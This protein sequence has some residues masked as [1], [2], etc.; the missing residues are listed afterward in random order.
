LAQKE[1]N[2]IDKDV[3]L[4]DQMPNAIFKS[5]TLEWSTTAGM[6]REKKLPEHYCY[7]N[8]DLLVEVAAEIDLLYHRVFLEKL[9]SNAVTCDPFDCGAPGFTNKPGI[10]VLF[11]GDH[12][13][14]ACLCSMKLNFSSPQQRKER[15]ELNWRCPTMQIASI[16]CSK[17]SFELLLNTVMPSIKSHLMS[18]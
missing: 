14:G 4:H 7:W 17:D 8:A 18:L 6:N 13:Q 12:G 10:I 9:N 5:H 2:R 16:D 3:G 1:V 15:K 11:G